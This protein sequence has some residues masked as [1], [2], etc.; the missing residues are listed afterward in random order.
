MVEPKNKRR[1]YH[2]RTT[3]QKA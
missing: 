2:G 1:F 3:S